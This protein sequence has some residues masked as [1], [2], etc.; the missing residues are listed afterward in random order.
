MPKYY[1][2]NAG[3]GGIRW[4]RLCAIYAKKTKQQKN[5]NAKNGK[6]CGTGKGGEIGS[7]WTYAKIVRKKYL[8]SQKEERRKH[9]KKGVSYEN[10]KTIKERPEGEAD[11]M[12]KID[13]AVKKQI[14]DKG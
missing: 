14:V 3:V 10:Y 9:R 8:G 13:A 2:K 6:K 7:S 11:R 5:I 1:E 12:I 4:K